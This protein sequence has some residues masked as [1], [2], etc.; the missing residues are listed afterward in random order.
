MPPLQQRFTMIRKDKEITKDLKVPKK[1]EGFEGQRTIILPQAKLKFCSQHIFCKNLYI[2]D[3][4]FYPHAAFHNR[5]RKNDCPQHILIHCVKGRGWYSINNEI[6]SVKTNDY[7]I[8]PA[9]TA[10]KYGADINDP[11][12]IYW[13]HFT[14][15][16][17]KYYFS[18]LTKTK[19][20][21][22]IN[23][24][25]NTSRQFL[26][27]DII[28][29]LELM[30]NTDNIIYSNSC[31]Y[32]FLS[33]FQTSEMKISVNENDIIQQCITFMKASLHK[34]LRLDDFS[35]QLNLSSSHLSAIFRKR[36][37][38]SPIHLFTSFK[39][40]KA[41]QMLMDSSQNVKTIAY[42]LGY[43]DPYHFSRVFKNIMGV[44]PK[45]FKN[46]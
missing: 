10:H 28:Q 34:N 24:I 16:F 21:G 41:C 5:E 17:A 35:S 9:N 37:K 13:V 31:L 23:A 11:W 36:M 29:H 45:K 27:Y 4:G 22:P 20:N 44:S 46:K 1:K 40:Q 25:V 8:I 14:G 18:L 32:A 33:S 6:H 38:Y 7:F 42:S 15:E 39:V 26:F 19:K 30:N 43:D 12:S 2:T 3:I